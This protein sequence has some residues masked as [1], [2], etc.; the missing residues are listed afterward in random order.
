MLFYLLLALL[1]I[2]IVTLSIKL[3]DGDTTGGLITCGL[4]ILIIYAGI[5]T[6]IGATVKTSTEPT[7]QTYQLTP[8]DN[9]TLNGRQYYLVKNPDGTYT[10][11]TKNDEGFIE[12][13]TTNNPKIAEDE[14][15]KPYLTLIQKNEQKPDLT[16]LTPWLQPHTYEPETIN[17]PEFHIPMNSTKYYI[18][19]ENGQQ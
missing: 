9:E 15:E 8:V 12:P 2:T 7:T 19:I 10:Y 1:I 11:A 13:K 5:T 3:K 18:S 17:Q 4:I 14:Q 6:A 16:W